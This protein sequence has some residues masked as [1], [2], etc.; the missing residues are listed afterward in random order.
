MCLAP[1]IITNPR[2][3]QGSVGLNYLFNTVDSK[4]QVPCGSCPQCASLRQSFFLQRVQMESLRSHLF[5]FTLTYNDDSLVYTDVGDYHIAFP[6]ISDVQN[7]FKRLRRQGYKFRYSYVSEYGSKRHR[8]HFHGILALDKSLGDPSS[9]EVKFSRLF[10]RE[11]KRNYGDNFSPVYRPLY[12]PVYKLCKCTTFD[13][14][15]IEPIRGHDNDVSFYISKY[16]TK[17]DKWIRAL[18]SKI[19]LDTSLSDDETS[20]LVNCLKPRCNI[21]KDFGYWC[22]PVI[23]SY[24]KK[25]AARESNYKYPQFFDINTGK[26]MPMSP[27]YAKR[28]VDFHH[29]F[30]RFLAS[31]AFDA[32]STNFGVFASVLDYSIQ[33]DSSKR[34]FDEFFSKLDKLYNRLDI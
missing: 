14:H 32:D 8:P 11:W 16:I 30:N 10:S 19:K 2:Y 18:L 17:Y 22:D 9:L 4:I 6:V 29:M 21:S 27:Y 34:Q 20:Y 25:C 28:V 12:T 3:K 1:I 5:M 23:F 26:S 31:D 15:Y 13:F 7:L 24:I 33:A